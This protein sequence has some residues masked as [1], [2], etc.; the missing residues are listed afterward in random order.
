M[1]V[2]V[3]RLSIIEEKL[4]VMGTI[5]VYT[6]NICFVTTRHRTHRI[7]AGLM[8]RRVMEIGL[9]CGTVLEC[10]DDDDFGNMHSLLKEGS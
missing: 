5:F 7:P 10:F 2:A 8:D 9:V 6:D 3:R 1:R 4:K